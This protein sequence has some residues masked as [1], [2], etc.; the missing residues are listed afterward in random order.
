M[1]L[2]VL[3][4]AFQDDILEN[5]QGVFDS[6][7]SGASVEEVAGVGVSIERM[8]TRIESGVRENTNFEGK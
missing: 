6:I 5:Q 3:Y 7:E 4:V 2:L 1:G 8:D